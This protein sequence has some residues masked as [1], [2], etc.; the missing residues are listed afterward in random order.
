ME[1]KNLKPCP[2]CGSTAIYE[3]PDRGR[4]IVACDF[5]A[6]SCGAGGPGVPFYADEELKVTY[7]K[8]CI[9]WNQRRLNN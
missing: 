7:G 1:S 8:A 2:F 3:S 5:S 6:A 9:E 4:A